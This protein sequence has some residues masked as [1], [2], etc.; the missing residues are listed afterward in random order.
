MPRIL[1]CPV[2]V[3]YA[4]VLSCGLAPPSTL[5]DQLHYSLASLSKVAGIFM[6]RRYRV[7]GNRLTIVTVAAVFVVA[8]AY[9]TWQSPLLASSATGSEILIAVKTEVIPVLPKGH[10]VDPLGTGIP[11]L[12][13]LNRKWGVERMVR[14]FPT[15]APDDQAAI[16]NG[17]AGVFKLVTRTRV[18][19]RAM[20]R[21]YQA[22]PHIDYAEPDA[23]FGINN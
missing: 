18:A 12:D 14:I 17:L 6:R 2:K 15:I 7:T 11:S 16:R 9:S 1:T 22:D 13:A 23:P 19:P 5:G 4:N 20:L 8:F 21:D 3:A 10:E